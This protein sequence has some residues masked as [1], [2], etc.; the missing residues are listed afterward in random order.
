M[1]TQTLRRGAS[2]ALLVL[3]AR[4]SQAQS[5]FSENFD[6]NTSANWSV[7]AGYEPA[8]GGADDDYVID[9]AFDYSQQGFN[10]F[11]APGAEPQALK[12][13][14]SP[15]G[16][17]TSRGL[18]ISV[19]NSAGVTKAVSLYPKGQ[20][21]SG[22]YVLKFDLFLNH[23]SYGGSGA[24]TT[25]YGT[26]GINHRGTNVNWARLSGANV[27]TD[28]RNAVGGATSDGLWF[29]ITGD[30]GAARDLWVLQGN[31]G[32]PPTARSDA[33]IP[34][35]DNN[36]AD[37]YPDMDDGEPYLQG[38]F[39]ATRFEA[40]GVPGKRWVQMEVAQYR[41][42]ITWKADG[43]VLVTYT[44]QTPWSAGTV[45]LGYLDPF[46][47]VAAVPEENWGLFDSLRVERIRTVVVDT[48]DNASGPGDGK[49]SLKEAL[50]GLQDNDVIAF[51]IPGAGPHYLVTPAGGYP[52]IQKSNVVIDGYTQ[53][54]ATPNTAGIT[55]PNTAQIRIVLDSRAGGRRVVD[56]PGFGTSESAILPL[57]GARNA[58]IRGLSFLSAQGGDSDEDPYIYGIALIKDST[59]A[60][61]QGNW[62]GVDPA[63]P[64]AAG[65]IG[66]RS[67][68][69]SFRWS[70]A[71]GEF[72]SSG[73]TIGP[74]SDGYGDT[75]EFNVM[76]GQLLALH[77]QTPEV[78]VAGNFINFL[79]NGTVFSPASRPELYEGKDFEA[80]ENGAGHHNVIGTDGDM[81][82]DAGEANL[83]GPVVYDVFF[84]F[85]RTATNVVV[86][87]NHIGVGLDG[88]P[89]FESPAP[90]S[91][92]ILR[93]NSSIRI[94][95]DFSGDATDT[96]Q[97]SIVAAD[98]LEGNKIARL[99]GNF[100]A[101]HG[102]NNDT[103]I[104]TDRPVRVSL[105]G[106]T[107]VGNYG[108][109][110]INEG[111]NVAVERLYTAVLASPET[112]SLPVVSTNTT[113]ST[114]AGR[115][116]A[117]AA[118]VLAEGALVEVDVYLADP[119]GL[120]KVDATF[121]KGWVQGRTY[122]GTFF[123]GSPV[124]D[125]NSNPGEFSFD[126]TPFNVSAADL[127]RLVVTAN[128]PL[129]AGPVVTSIFSLPTG[130]AVVPPPP[131]LA[132]L[133]ASLDGANLKLTWT[134]GKAPFT[135]QRRETLT[136]TWA[137]AAT[138]SAR[139]YA[140]PAAATAALFRVV[141]SP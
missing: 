66:G 87:G 39:P 57:L 78:K 91:L 48:A 126:I 29:G 73:L 85:W 95:S 127:G 129:A 101:F 105:R 69:A 11:T 42:V 106:N 54:G 119:E 123:E 33:F 130:S 58:T 26:F 43:K 111:Q 13:P 103:A 104:E 25:Q 47:G 121:P 2:L 99:G 9:W 36:V 132:D 21:F 92:A 109:I 133:K 77:L 76:V 31:D 113:V 40:P 110:P 64:T 34:N 107:L 24:G 67:A 5:L 134:G 98:R 96:N 53:P 108:Q 4:S 72:Y 138:V 137:D 59:G 38:V 45:M 82:N 65:V 118:G 100:L 90:T 7:Y 70:D 136:G 115:I 14:P 86:A 56:Y 49:T 83:I 60:R 44:N 28:F 61:V 55:A 88:A 15:N 35:R 62:F 117:A 102:S 79:P 20:N 128:Y 112:D 6:T 46:A 71:T 74:A 1:K 84:E 50:E 94:G 3:L 120:S 93:K 23:A 51:N 124:D 139:E 17:G 12:V 80:Y 122:L 141:G 63:N 22:D 81:I 18:K 8:A 89:L 131:P 75:A 68:V 19:N 140:T 27:R 10:L 125:G 37:V 114:L 52:L 16:G 135:V 97:V 116:P 30:G 32:A 41:N